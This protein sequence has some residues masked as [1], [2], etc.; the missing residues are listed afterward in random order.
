MAIPL[1]TPGPSGLEFQIDKAGEQVLSESV[2]VVRAVPVTAKLSNKIGLSDEFGFDRIS[3]IGGKFQRRVVTLGTYIPDGTT[4]RLRHNAAPISSRRPIAGHGHVV[5]IKGMPSW[6][7]SK[8]GDYDSYRYIYSD[9]EKFQNLLRSVFQDFKPYDV[10]HLEMW[11]EASVIHEW[12]DGIVNLVS[13]HA[14][15]AEVARAELP[16]LTL[17]GGCTHTWD[18]DFLKGFVSSG[19]ASHCDGLAVHGYTYSPER[20]LEYFSR[21]EDIVSECS[22]KT[23]RPFQAY[24]TE[25]GFRTPAFSD[26]LQALYLFLYSL[27]AAARK[28]VASLIWF[29]FNNVRHRSSATYDQNASDGYGMVGYNDRYCRPMIAAYRNYLRLFSKLVSVEVDGSAENRR[30]FLMDA[31]GTVS[32]IVHYSTN[33]LAPK[34]LSGFQAKNMYGAPVSPQIFFSESDPIIT[35][36]EREI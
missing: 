3:V 11:N 13:L 14:A 35:V 26:H 31:G 20:F 8:E 24:I 29:R 1:P 21:L 33:G 10:T 7:S 27:E 19:G 15:I 32:T 16:D 4:F 36:F 9:K 12:N 30:F 18:F 2:G 17:L 6:M 22:D 34:N 25:I 5:A 28:S 23:G